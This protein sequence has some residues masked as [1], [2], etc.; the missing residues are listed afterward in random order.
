[1]RY[2]LVTIL[3][4]ACTT[5]QTVPYQEHPAVDKEYRC[6]I[7]SRITCNMNGESDLYAS[8]CEQEEFV[9]C[10]GSR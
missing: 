8:R 5:E 3:L 4:T 1:M 10:M 7:Q 2:L 9:H 6:T